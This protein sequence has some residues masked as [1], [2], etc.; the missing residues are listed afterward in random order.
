MVHYIRF[1]SPPKVIE[2]A[3]KTF[4]I[5]AVL[6]VTTDLGD[7][8]YPEDVALRCRVVSTKADKTVIR[9]EPL[10]WKAGSRAL[11]VTLACPAKHA[12]LSVRMHIATSEPD[13]SALVPAI[14]DVWSLP[15][16]LKD[17]QRADPFVDREFVL[18]TGST[19]QIREETGD[20]I[21]R[22]IWD[23]SLGFLL[24][25]ESALNATATD[26]AFSRLLV[27]AK[28][29]RLRVIELGAGC[30]IVGI[31][32]ASLLKCDMILTDLDDA[33]EILD[34]NLTL[35]SG[36]ADTEIRAEVLDWSTDLPDSLNTKYDLVLVS[37]C[38]YNPESSV[39]LVE[40]LRRLKHTSPSAVILVGY[41][42]RH[43]ADD[44]FFDSM[45]TAKFET[46][47]SDSIT[48]P[49]TASEYDASTP[50]IEFYIYQQLS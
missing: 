17:K 29:K 36:V 37:D 46:L 5:S 22:H 38:V 25:L 49:H 7:A 33:T 43:S 47:H 31:A 6:A 40:T 11:K 20:S 26:N 42:R 14:L 2:A 1:L 28:S 8:Y 16:D 18:S 19:L 44:I 30:G 10:T 35:A 39:R 24:F 27:S 9:D 23:A 21:A 15:F 41:K 4:N 12:S 13:T 50:T 45:K 32:F 48:L 34:A 3:K